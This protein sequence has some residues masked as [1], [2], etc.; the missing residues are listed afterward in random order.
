MINIQKNKIK[1]SCKN[2]W[3]LFGEKTEEFLKNNNY[4]F[5]P[6]FEYY[7]FLYF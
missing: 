2:L 1:F 6:S 7:I 5:I 3:K 4:I